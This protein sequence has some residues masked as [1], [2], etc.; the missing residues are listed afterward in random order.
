[1]IDSQGFRPNV[2]I[3]LTNGTRRVFW[4]KRKGQ[5]AWQFPQGGISGSET[6][7]E[8]MFRELF[9]E[10]GLKPQHVEIMGQT[11]RWLRYRLPKRMIRRHSLPLCIG[12]KQR[13]FLLRLV[14]GEHC[15]K[16]DATDT[17]EFDGWRWVDYWYPV[18]EVVYFKRKV[19]Q[20]AL[21]ELAPLIFPESDQ[22]GVLQSSLPKGR[23]KT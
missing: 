6:P 1:M 9:E 2:G 7:E 20:L 3:I 14:G 12:Q 18:R 4:A 13:W 21:N 5:N 11:Q 19:Y 22:E 15:F 10:T 16:L 17:P 23:Y 8:A